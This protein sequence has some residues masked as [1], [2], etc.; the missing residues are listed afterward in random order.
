MQW[1]E[2]LKP[3]PARMLRQFAVL[4]L[5]VFGSMGA[6]RVW[7]GSPEWGWTLVG[8]AGVVGLL[9]IARPLAIRR[10][11]TGWMV[12]VFPIGWTVSQLMLAALF[13]GMFMPVA[14][15]FK[16]IGRDALRVRRRPVETY[17]VPRAA[18]DERSYFQQF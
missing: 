12:A 10:I 2:V 18:A 5:V 11:Y 8:L 17:Y 1:A 15:L 14:L 16:L 13:Y 7:R 3:P 9:G 6:W 4:W